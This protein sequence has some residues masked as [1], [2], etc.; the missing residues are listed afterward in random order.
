MCGIDG[1]F[2]RSATQ[3]VAERDLRQMLAM[4][5]HRGPDEF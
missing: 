4:L 5:R 3:S 1:M 2:N